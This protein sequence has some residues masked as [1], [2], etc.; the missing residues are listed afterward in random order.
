MVVI[1]GIGLVPAFRNIIRQYPTI[2]ATDSTPLLANFLTYSG[3]K[4]SLNRMKYYI[5]QI[6]FQ[7]YYGNI[8]DRIK[9]FLPRT[10]WCASSLRHHYRVKPEKILITPV[11]FD[12][13]QWIKKKDR[14]KKYPILLF[15]GN[16]FQRKGGFL[17]I[18]IFSKYL[19]QKAI[20]QIV[21][22]DPVLKTI[23]LPQRIQLHSG[24][25]YSQK[26]KLMELYQNADVLLLPTKHDY[27]PI[28][29]IEGCAAGL[30]II[31]SNIGAVSE[32]VEDGVNGYLMPP[33]A[34]EGEWVKK[35]N[36]LIENKEKREEF[37]EN[38]RKLAQRKFSIEIF[39]SNFKKAF[40]L[41]GYE[42]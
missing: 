3:D 34:T 30:P 36:Y 21:S 11:S 42:I 29:L 41:T 38:S 27:L 20:L 18:D 33:F 13:N 8:L 26:H 22:N 9:A 2:L 37:G 14:S 24:I 1:Q 17:L 28:V 4:S 19:S 39:K 15:V 5:K 7:W 16:D 25:G 10:E 31:A 35:I 23:Q 6:Y 12:L 32:A 40:F